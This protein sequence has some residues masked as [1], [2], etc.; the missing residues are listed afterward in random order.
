MAIAKTKL[1]EAIGVSRSGLYYEERRSEKDA[2]LACEI[3]LELDRHGTYGH[4]RIARAL[5]RGKN[6]VLRVMKLFRLEP[7]RRKPKRLRKKADEHTRAIPIPNVLEAAEANRPDAAWVEDFTYLRCHGSFVYLATVLDVATREILGFALRTRH[8][9]ELTLSALRSA[10][11]SGRRPQIVHSDQ[12][13]EYR[14]K[15]RLVLLAERGIQASMSRKASPW[16]N[17]HQEGFFSQFKLDLGDV[18]R[19]ASVGELAEEV[20]QRIRDYNASRIHSALGMPPARFRE[21]FMIM[22]HPILETQRSEQSHHTVL[23]CV[24]QETG[25]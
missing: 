21:R 4:R 24:S 6:S 16:E 2:A 7:V 14:A 3:A 13:S 11:A 1:A 19:F 25:T 12:G 22:K 10:F 9:A 23:D 20:S 5:G 15:E 18:N 8:T 17:P